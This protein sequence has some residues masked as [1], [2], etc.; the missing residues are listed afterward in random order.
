MV[1]QRSLSLSCEGGFRR[2]DALVERPLRQ[3]GAAMTGATKVAA[4]KG[5]GLWESERG[6]RILSVLCV[7]MLC[8]LGT[9]KITIKAG[10]ED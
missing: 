2:D 9:E 1:H 10:S 3:P 6:R 7:T 4:L 8:V 5:E